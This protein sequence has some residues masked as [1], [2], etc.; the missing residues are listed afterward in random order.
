MDTLVSVL[1][2]LNV[3]SSSGTYTPDQIN[4]YAVMYAGPI[5]NAEQAPGELAVIL[6]D[7]ETEAIIVIDSMGG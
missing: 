4:N 5:A 6:S 3:I 2:Y 1:L 7:Y